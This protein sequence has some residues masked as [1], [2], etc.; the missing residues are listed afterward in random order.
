MRTFSYSRSSAFIRGLMA[1]LIVP[2]AGC[3]LGTS[4]PAAVPAAPQPVVVQPPVPDAPLSI[5]Q[6]AVVLPSPQPVNP[7]A[8]PATPAEPVSPAP[9]P[10]TTAVAPQRPPRRPPA[11]PP[12][13]EPEPEAETPAAPAIQ[14]LEE[15]PTIQ[16]ILTPDEQKK[17]KIVIDGYKRE[18][19]DWLK[20]AQAHQS[21]SNHALVERISSFVGQSD[22]AAK[23]G[24][25][26]QAENLY[27]RALVLAKELQVE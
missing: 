20:R 14:P 1:L 8:I 26:T 3:M 17:I 18:I 19:N 12:K 22:E 11:G 25:L 16:P 23:R 2:L 7:G 10:D 27:Q 9:K 4:K 21:S 13:P 6:T 15:K 5:P 24:D